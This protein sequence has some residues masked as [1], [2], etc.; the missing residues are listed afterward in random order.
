MVDALAQAHFM[1]G[2]GIAIGDGDQRSTVEIGVRHT[3]DHVRGAGAAGGEADAGSAGDFAPGGGEH[4]AGHFLLHQDE[5]HVAL[6]RRLHQLDGFTAGM[7]DDERRA[8]FLERI[9]HHFNGRRHRLS[10][11]MI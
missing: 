9:R 4:G 3:V 2:N 1:L 10:L 6:T 7:A 5:A 8:R 11:Q